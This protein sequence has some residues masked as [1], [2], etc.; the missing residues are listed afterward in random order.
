MGQ[1]PKISAL[2]SRCDAA[3][4]CLPLGVD[5]FDLKKLDKLIQQC[6]PLERNQTLC[7]SGKTF[8]FLHIIKKGSF[9]SISLRANG[10]EQVRGFY[11]PGELIGVEAIASG[12]YPYTTIAIEKSQVC[13]IPY[14]QFLQI[15]GLAPS[16]QN[17]L[18]NLISQRM[19]HDSVVPRHAEAGV[20]LAE[21]ILNLQ[22]RYQRTFSQPLRVPMSRQDIGNYLGLALETISRLLSKF[23]QQG[24]LKVHGKRIEIISLSAL[25][26]YVNPEI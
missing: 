18:F 6:E 8:E 21:F 24:W 20:R 5:S 14:S 12:H 26:T 25:Q 3:N 4:I 2:C 1:I 16:L 19:C 23:Q 11:L 9:K 10:E 17:R 7:Q 13:R 22:E 15:L